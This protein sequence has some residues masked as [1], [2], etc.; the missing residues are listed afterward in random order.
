MA[1]AVR[2]GYTDNNPVRDAERPRDNGECQK[3]IR[4]LT[5]DEINAYLNFVADR[6]HHVLFKLAIMS[7]ARQGELLGLKWKDI[8]WESNQIHIQRTFN[9]SGWYNPKSATSNRK[10]DIGPVMMLDLKMEVG[11]PKE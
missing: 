8:D 3:K 2:H 7:G 1:Y 6:K 11:M 4:I 10:I 9:N 5:P